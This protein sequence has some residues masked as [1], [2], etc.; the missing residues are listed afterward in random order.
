M[1]KRAILIG[2][3]KQKPGAVRNSDGRTERQ[4]L[5]TM[6]D[7]IKP[8]WT[9]SANWLVI[10]EPQGVSGD[11]YSGIMSRIE[12]AERA[13][14]EF[15]IELHVNN[16]PPGQKDNYALILYS[17]GLYNARPIAEAL[18]THFTDFL[19]SAG[20]EKIILQGIPDPKWPNFAA[21]TMAHYPA[22]IFEPFFI[23]NPRHKVAERLMFE[24]CPLMVNF[25]ETYNNKE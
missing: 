4:I 12:Q 19:T 2:H 7:C 8:H 6:R 23:N 14:V 5:E 1:N 20:L 25:M 10:D 22:I 24:F 13:G 3:T 15:G 16:I 9:R 11:G 21:L 18:K 17:A